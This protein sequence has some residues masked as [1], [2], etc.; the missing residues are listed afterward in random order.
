MRLILKAQGGNDTMLVSHFVEPD[1]GL[2]YFLKTRGQRNKGALTDFQIRDQAPTT[3][4]QNCELYCVCVCV[5][6]CMCVCLGGGEVV[7]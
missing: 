5:R 2:I 4:S 1:L 3:D 6:V 7:E